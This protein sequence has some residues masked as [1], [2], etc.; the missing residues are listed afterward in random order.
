VNWTTTSAPIRGRVAYA[1]V[2]MPQDPCPTYGLGT[3]AWNWFE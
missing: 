2:L 1:D 3:E